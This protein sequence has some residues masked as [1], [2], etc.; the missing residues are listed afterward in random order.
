MLVVQLSIPIDTR[1]FDIYFSNNPAPL[2]AYGTPAITP[3]D[4]L[5]NA[6]YVVLIVQFFCA[7]VTAAIFLGIH[8][9]VS[10]M[11]PASLCTSRAGQKAV[12]G[13]PTTR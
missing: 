9:P 10:I 8:C 2:V 3:M 6:D 4:R 7:P 11:I 5:Q 12:K 1:I 13:K